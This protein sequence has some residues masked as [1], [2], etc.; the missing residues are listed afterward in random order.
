MAST[1]QL[2]VDGESL[3]ALRALLT[4]PKFV[5]LPGT[6]TAAERER[7]AAAFDE[8]LSRLI[9]GVEES[10]TKSW[11]LGQFVRT[12]EFAAGEDTEARERFGP[13]FERVMDILG[14]E[15]SDGLL[16]SYL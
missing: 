13:Y 15:T 6:D 8:L 7:C 10:P 14:I 3:A 4:A 2:L 9:G 16:N 1:D 5:D 12:L 11:V